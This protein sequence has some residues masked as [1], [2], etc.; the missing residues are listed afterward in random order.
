MFVGVLRISLHLSGVGSLKAKRG[1]V[2][3]VVDRTRSKFNAAVAEVAGN[4]SLAQAVIGVAVVGNRAAHVDS[5]LARV[6]RFVEQMSTAPVSRI[7]TEVLP[8]GDELAGGP[9]G[10]GLDDVGWAGDD[11][12]EDEEW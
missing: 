8:L 6:A 7:E 4:D 12:E 3:R 9:P 2:R 1:V 11:G 5:M 10:L